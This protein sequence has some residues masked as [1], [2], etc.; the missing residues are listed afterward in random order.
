MNEIV[1]DIMLWFSFRNTGAQIMLMRNKDVSDSRW[2]I[3]QMPVLNSD[4]HRF[5]FD[6]CKA[7]A[8]FTGMHVTV[9]DI[10]KVPTFMCSR[11]AQS[12]PTPVWALQIDYEA[13]QV[14]NAKLASQGYEIIAP[15]ATSISW[16]K[17]GEYLDDLKTCAHELMSYYQEHGV[18]GHA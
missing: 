3:L 16:D 14:V 9:H 11:D 7:A 1:A 5:L 2:W 15:H 10:E 12:L 13:S 4:P 17:A 8:D 6:L 18:Y